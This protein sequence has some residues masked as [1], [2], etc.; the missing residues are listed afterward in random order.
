MHH[1]SSDIPS[2]RPRCRAKPPGRRFLAIPISLVLAIVPLVI[3]PFA[4]P[5]LASHAAQCGAQT[6]Y[7]WAG[8][9]KAS[10]QGKR[11]D[12]IRAEIQAESIALCTGSTA[13]ARN[14][15]IWVAIVGSCS[16]CILQLGMGRAEPQQAMGWWWAWGRNKEAAGCENY[17]N[18]APG[19]QR[20]SD[21]DARQVR[22]EINRVLSSTISLWVFVID[23][24]QKKDLSEVQVCWAN[25][26][27]DWFGEAM[28]RGSAIGGFALDPI[29]VSANRYRV[30]NDATW[31]TP[32]W[33]VGSRCVFENPK[34]PYNCR[35]KA[36]DTL[37]LWSHNP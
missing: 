17:T 29:D 23:G 5:A 25:M 27:A 19:V 21:W 1:V 30:Q 36:G 24:R 35:A 16:H 33:T 9:R 15:Y 28:N 10:T 4:R 14:S 12:G 8:H 37:E 31:Y 34:P 11:I 18:V 32:A 2:F 7:G 3:P 20:I 6:Q 22:Y 13:A 26:L